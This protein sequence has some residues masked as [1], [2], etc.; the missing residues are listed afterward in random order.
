ML[1]DSDQLSYNLMLD[2]TG[3]GLGGRLRLQAKDPPAEGWLEG[4]GCW[5]DWNGTEPVGAGVWDGDGGQ[6]TGDG[7]SSSVSW[8]SSTRGNGHCQGLRVQ[9]EG[10]R[11]SAS[12]LLPADPAVAL[13]APNTVVTE[14]AGYTCHSSF[15]LT[16]T[17][18]GGPGRR[19]C[20]SGRCLRCR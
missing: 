3:P 18:P 13:P 2:L 5:R 15:Y 6:G 7:C 12:A 4:D 8:S 9:L 14:T 20:S 17:G 19:S 1:E 16:S 10:V 11:S